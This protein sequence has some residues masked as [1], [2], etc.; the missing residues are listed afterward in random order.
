[1]VFPIF[2]F[3]SSKISFIENLIWV[4]GTRRDEVLAVMQLKF[5]CR[6]AAKTHTQKMI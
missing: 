4:Q 6:L 1:M 2:L 3:I 5:L